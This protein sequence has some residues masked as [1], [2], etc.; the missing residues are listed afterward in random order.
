MTAR[1]RSL[2]ITALLLI[3]AVYPVGP[4]LNALV[5]AE[6]R[7]V[8][9][10]PPNPVASRH[11]AARKL[12]QLYELEHRRAGVDFFNVGPDK[13]CGYDEPELL[14][15]VP[16]IRLADGSTRA[17]FAERGD[18][19]L[20][21]SADEMKRANKEEKRAVG[22]ERSLGNFGLWFMT[23]CIDNTVLARVCDA[24]VGRLIERIDREPASPDDYLGID[25][26]NK[27]RCTHLDG[28]AARL[29]L[30]IAKQTGP[31]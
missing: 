9:P 8:Y 22:L 20:A 19:Y 3:L 13:I 16:R 30:P 4:I 27:A 24:H 10:P 25:V 29:G 28:V 23:D 18:F 2:L 12:A 14:R 11:L 17:S 5:R 21:G 31:M 1:R 6:I 15:K 7:S 26:W